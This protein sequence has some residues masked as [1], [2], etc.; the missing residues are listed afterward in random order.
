VQDK[1]RILR[2]TDRAAESGGIGAILRREGVYSS[3]LTDWRRQRDAGAFSALSPVRRGPKMAEPNPLEADL[4]GVRRENA[5]LRRRLEQAEAI[6]EVQKKVA[7]L[8]GIPLSQ[9]DS[10][11]GL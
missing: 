1:M 8:L 6:I 7:A 3:T 5:R 11:D 4:A 2:E 9:A 10:D